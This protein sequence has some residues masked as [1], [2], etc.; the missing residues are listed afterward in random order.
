VKI[1]CTARIEIEIEDE[2]LGDLLAAIVQRITVAKPTGSV[3]EPSRQ[4]G[5]YG[6]AIGELWSS[7]PLRT[8][9]PLIEASKYPQGVARHELMERFGDDRYTWAARFRKLSGIMQRFA[10]RPWPYDRSAERFVVL[11]ELADYI[12][13]LPADLTD[14]EPPVPQEGR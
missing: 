4:S 14:D 11:P 8:K 10:G 3:S 1:H 2:S 9:E 6:E 12:R 13:R 5:R 7:L